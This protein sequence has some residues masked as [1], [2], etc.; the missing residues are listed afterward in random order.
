LSYAEWTQRWW[1]WAYG[2]PVDGHPLFD[3]TGADCAAGQSGPVWF[4]G[5]VFNVSGSA[6]RT[7]CSVPTGKALFFPILNVEWD[8]ICPPIEPPM[9]IEE[10][11]AIAASFMDLA[12]DLSCELD[13]RPI[14]NLDRYRFAG[15]PFGVDIP[16]GSI[17]EFFGCATPA[18]HYE[19]LVPDGFYLMLAPLS[20]GAHVLHFRG[21]VGD[22]VNFTLDITYHLNVV[23]DGGD[24]IA[25]PLEPAVG[26]TV[27]PSNEGGREPT[28]T[29]WGRVKV[30]YR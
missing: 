10:L 21:T 14:T 3:E 18:G 7:L 11:R 28:T 6:D 9:T 4:L 12:T 5:G 29:S 27:G 19:P 20:P 24:A 13:G 25:A 16:S 1:Q 26:G 22:P 2:L 15:D 17:W 30:V 23:A 8:N